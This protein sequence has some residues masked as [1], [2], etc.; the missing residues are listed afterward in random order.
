[1]ICKQ[2]QA[3]VPRSNIGF[4]NRRGDWSCPCCKEYN[5]GDQ[6]MEM[7][8]QNDA[9]SCIQEKWISIVAQ[10]RQKLEQQITDVKR[11]DIGDL[12]LLVETA[13]QLMNMEQDAHTF[14]HFVNLNNNRTTWERFN[15]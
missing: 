11:E 2:C 13:G 9:L 10:M 8:D 4:H 3:V 15:G 5:Y 6:R 12:S 7:D 14:E 1:M